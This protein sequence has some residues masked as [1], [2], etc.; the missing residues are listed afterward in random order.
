MRRTRIATTLGAAALATLAAIVPQLSSAASP[1]KT[2]G[3]LTAA[4]AA[5]TDSVLPKYDHVVIAIYENKK[6][7]DIKG[8]SSAP[9][10]NDLA[11]QGTLF[12][13]SFGLTHPS[14][15]NYI[16]L[17]SGS[18]QG[19]DD[20]DCPQSFSKGNLGQQLIDKGLSFKAYSEGLPSAGSTK[21]ESGDYRRKH[22]PWADFPT[23]SDAAHHVP[24]SQFPSDYGQLPTVSFVVPD[25]CHDMHNVDDCPISTGD[26]WTKNNLDAYA[27]WAKTHNSL[28][29][30]TFDEDWKTSVNQIFTSFVGA[31]V[32]PGYESSTHIDH[33]TVLR[34]IEDMY[35]LPALGNAADRSAIT[36]VW[37]MPKL[38][39][40]DPG[41]QSGAVGAEAS[42]QLKATSGTAPYT[43]SATGLPAGLSIDSSSGLIS[44]TPTSA[45][46]SKVTVTAK[47][48][49]GVSGSVV[50]PWTT[51][52]DGSAV[53]ADDFESDLGWTVNPSATDT[54]KVGV[55]ERGNPEE[56]TS[57]YSDQ[58][59]QLGKTVSGVN[60]LSTG[61]AAGAAYGD[62]DLDGGVSS[63]RSGEISLPASGSL[64]LKLSYNVAHG[65]NSGSDDYLKVNVVDGSAVKTV[66]TKVGAADSEVA[67]SWQTATADLSAFAGKSV[68]I[69]IE[70]ADA[71]DPSLFEAQVDDLSITK[72]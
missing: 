67:G 34:T 63:I 21:C 42:L 47:D 56:T 53:F 68:R 19:V 43:W 17:F 61:A 31:H 3:P 58:V 9:Y 24:F 71:G 69:S 60:A 65:N 37:E 20:D 45:G 4:P 66:F 2:A 55:W 7:T 30:T 70:A 6:Y 44:G 51:S 33:Y 10:F 16:G 49:A 14:Q 28:L 39:I 12:T 41:S 57:T 11:K 64:T 72:G 1:D 46:T 48:S 25:M 15:P 13:Q 62:N 54:A 27:Q 26:T 38:D 22:A 23:V 8:N 59:K 52:A 40:A 36:D 50:F 35:G 5:A 29:V 18:L 32:K